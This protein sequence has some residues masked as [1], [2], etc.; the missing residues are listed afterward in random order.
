MDNSN[1]SRS[2]VFRAAK[3]IHKPK[4]LGNIPV[5][6]DLSNT[7]RRGRERARSTNERYLKSM[8]QGLKDNP[9]LTIIGT[10][11]LLRR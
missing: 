7:L 5:Q 6:K 10:R 1:G 9:D 8:R 3:W 2:L 4:I 11:M